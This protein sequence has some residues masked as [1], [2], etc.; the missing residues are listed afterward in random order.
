MADG[1]AIE[2]RRTQSQMSAIHSNL[3]D[4]IG[5]ITAGKSFRKEQRQGLKRKLLKV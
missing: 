4:A 5:K 3:K 1:G 2:T